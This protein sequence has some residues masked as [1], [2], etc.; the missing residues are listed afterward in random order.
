MT[1]NVMNHY[2]FGGQLIF[3]DI[4]TFID[5]RADQLFLGGFTKKFS[6]GPQS[7]DALADSFRQYDIGW[8]LFPPGDAR[9]ALLDGMAGWLRVYSDAFTVIHR[10]NEAQ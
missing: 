4:K 10:R 1:G 9:V 5:G 7:Q 8:T 3:N 6:S 2:N